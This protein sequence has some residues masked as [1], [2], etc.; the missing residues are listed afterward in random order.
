[1]DMNE[2]TLI[3]YFCYEIIYVHRREEVRESSSVWYLLA[4][5]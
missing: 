2:S 4:V 5:H 3:G 1:M